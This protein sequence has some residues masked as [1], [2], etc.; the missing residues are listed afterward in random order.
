MSRWG[1]LALG[2]AV[3]AVSLWL[4]FRKV[5]FHE[6]AAALG[7]IATPA[8]AAC[9][10]C[11]SLALLL[12]T[13]R[14]RLLLTANGPVPFATVFSINAAGQMGNMILPARLG[15]VYR[16]TNLQKAGLSA[17][18]GLATVVSERI[19]DAGFMVLISAV[20]LMTVENL[21]TWVAHSSRVMAVAALAGLLV[22]VLL[23]R[24]ANLIERVI[25]VLVPARYVGAVQNLAQQFLDGLKSFQSGVRAA[26]FLGLTVAVWL[27]DGAGLALL[28]RGMHIDLSATEAALVLA[29]IALSAVVPAAPGNLG[30]QQYVAMSVLVPLGAQ[31]AQAVTFALLLQFMNTVMLCSWGSL[32]AWLMA[33]RAST[34]EPAILEVA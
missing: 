30:V 12:R 14:W 13:F 26:A 25:G 23:P 34:A 19:L 3:S 22:T 10:A 33:R 4:A 1:K 7:Q 20:A 6:V 11:G 8:L 27:A 16:A 9:F 32:G 18:Y 31:A 24:F 5:S 17:G 2:V 28:A 15:D 21:P 29:S